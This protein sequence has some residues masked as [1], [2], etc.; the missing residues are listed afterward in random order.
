MGT[1]L[2]TGSGTAGP[3]SIKL[4]NLGNSVNFAVVDIDNDVPVYVYGSDK[5]PELN[6][7][8]EPKKQSRLTV[9]VTKADGAMTGPR[10]EERAIEPGELASIY[11]SG[12]AKWDPDRDKLADA[13][14]VSWSAA[15]EK[16]GGLAV[17]HVGQYAYVGDIPSTKPGN[18]PRKDRKF[19]LRQPKPEEAAQVERCEELRVAGH[20]PPTQLEPAGGPRPAIE[21]F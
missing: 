20:A 11:I 5:V 15:C 9:L 19:A 7:K 12:Y 1:P 13:T 4:P 3:P 2:D 8:G 21:D 16:A 18:D 6:Y 14:H 10:G 17:G